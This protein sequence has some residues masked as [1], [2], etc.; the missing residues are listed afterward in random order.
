MFKAALFDLD[1]VVF[2]TEPQ[3][4][5]FWGKQCKLY[6]P[7]QPSLEQKIKGQTLTQIYDK[8]FNNEL[9]REQKKITA[10]LDE[11]EQNMKF[12]YID[13]FEEYIHDL[14]CR[15]IKTAVVTSS[16]DKK[17][18]AVYK[19]H[20]EFKSIFD[21]ILTADDFTKSK[22]DPE[23]YVNAAKLF[24]LE[25]NECVV[26][27]DSFNGLKSGRAANMSVVGLSTT[28]AAES[29]SEF[30]D[31]VIEDYQGIDYQK[32]CDIITSIH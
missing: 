16:N 32:T 30:A 26:F 21:L 19:E 13:G 24:G 8:Y 29:I 31:A 7:D 20:P 22:P 1:G 6:H 10:R 14:K 17:M 4:T 3:Y 28:N 25:Q 23:C 11:F 5:V 27:E 12:E 18:Q 9:V 2:D 15:G